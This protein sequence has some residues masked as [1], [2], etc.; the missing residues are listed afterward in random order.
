[1][2]NRRQFLKIASASASMVLAPAALARSAQPD[3][4]DRILSL[5]NIHTGEQLRATYWSDGSYNVEELAAIDYL[6]RDHRSKEIMA[7]DKR[8]YDLLFSLQQRLETKGSFQVISG[9]RSPATNASLRKAGSGVAKRSL[10]MLG[11]AVDIRLPGV[12]LKQL[13]RAA[14]DLGQ[15]G[16]GYY[17]QSN[18]IHLDTGR[19]RFW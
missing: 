14:L 5:H 18:F 10:H 15:G 16:V 8:L 11:K 13:R 1:M 17:P 3:R 9:Y 19:R 4:A 12:E 6:L 7:M 2:P